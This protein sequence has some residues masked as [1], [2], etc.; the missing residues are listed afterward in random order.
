MNKVSKKIFSYFLIIFSILS[1]FVGFYLNENSAGAG[2][3]VFGDLKN[4]WNNLNT[5]LN[6]SILDGVHLTTSLNT[7]VYKSSRTPLIY[8]IHKIFELVGSM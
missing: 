8:I 1:Y 4:T 5:F 7:D 3:L 6:N 2:S